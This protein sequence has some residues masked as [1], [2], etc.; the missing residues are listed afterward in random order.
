MIHKNK[1]ILVSGSLAYDRI[2]DFPGFFKDHILPDKIH[3]LN[4][5]FAVNG[6]KENFGGTAGNIAYNLALLNEKPIILSC[7]G[8][9]FA[10]YKKWFAQNKVNSS[11]VKKI[12]SRNTASA[13]IITDQADNQITG[14]NPGA[15]RFARGAF[16]KK[17]LRNS[18]AII[19]PG[20][21]NDMKQ[22]AELYKQKKVKYIFDPGQ[23]IT[24]L[25]KSALKNSIN[26][27]WILIGNDYEISA[28]KRKIGWTDKALLGKITMLVVT[29]GAKG[30]E[31]Y[32]QSQRIKIPAAKP[33]SILDPTGAGDA[34]RA[35]LIKG[36]IN[37]WPL[38]KAGRLA[39]L[40]AVYA[41]EKY[42]TQNHKFTR[43]T[44]QKRYSENF[45]ENLYY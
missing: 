31:I 16:N 36:L 9:G 41:V 14:F 10:S 34:Y 21:N 19:A 18:I 24:S 11:Q 45:G 29:K 23:E 4:V 43:Q 25:K 5:S 35:G 1:H 17:L 20:N 44:L 3:I 42:G 2:M 38:E 28:I 6:I 30:S 13:N 22:Y 27:A 39:G 12:K 32:Y 26:G 7:A 8:K 40:V 33:R 15:L 37:G